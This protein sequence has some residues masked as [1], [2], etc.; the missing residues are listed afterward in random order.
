[1]CGLNKYRAALLVAEMEIELF[2]GRKA[3]DFRKG[4]DG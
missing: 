2:P 4:L 3:G 1:V